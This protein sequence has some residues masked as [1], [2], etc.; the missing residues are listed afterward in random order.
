MCTE[1][2]Y[3]FIKLIDIVK[4]EEIKRIVSN[5]KDDC[6]EKILRKAPRVNEEKEIWRFVR[7]DKD[8]YPYFISNPKLF[9]NRAKKGRNKFITCMGCGLSVFLSKE[10]TLTIIKEKFPRQK[11]RIVKARY[12]PEIGNLYITGVNLKHCT[13]FP[14]EDFN[15]DKFFEVICE[16]LEGLT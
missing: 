2:K 13:L 15:H 5:I 14:C 8:K 6:P 10:D 11:F 12:K 9:K 7:G 16:V 1:R 4:D 3:D